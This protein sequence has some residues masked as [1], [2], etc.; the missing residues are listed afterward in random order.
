MLSSACP[1]PNH[2]WDDEVFETLVGSAIVPP[3]RIVEFVILTPDLRVVVN[4][5]EVDKDLAL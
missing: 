2:E 4:R 5:M 3:V 1:L